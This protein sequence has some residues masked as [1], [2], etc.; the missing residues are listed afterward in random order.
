MKSETKIICPIC[1]AEYLPE[2]IYVPKAFFG[3]QDYI[4]K[5]H[6]TGKLKAFYGKGMD[7]T[8]QYVCD[9]CHNT[10]NIRAEVIFITT[11]SD[12]VSKSQVTKQKL[13]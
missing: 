9:H 12:D 1:G 13:F 11:K 4:E 2:E 5:D 6:N 3:K 10:F 7:L 8:E